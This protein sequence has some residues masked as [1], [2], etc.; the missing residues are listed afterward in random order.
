MT[1][2]GRKQWCFPLR[3]PKPLHTLDYNVESDLGI[4][5]SW[6]MLQQSIF[7]CDTHTSTQLFPVHP[8]KAYMRQSTLP[9]QFKHHVFCLCFSVSQLPTVSTYMSVK[10][11]YTVFTLMKTFFFLFIRTFHHIH[12]PQLIESDSP[13]MWQLFMFMTWLRC[14]PNVTANKTLTYW[15]LSNCCAEHRSQLQPGRLFITARWLIL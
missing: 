1:S 14:C 15:H 5:L 7:S 8:P 3:N 4:G 6:M 10:E 9:L 13:V 2:Y 12:V 11:L